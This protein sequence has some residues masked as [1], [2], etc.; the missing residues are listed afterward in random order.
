MSR[1]PIRAH[2]EREIAA[3]LRDALEVPVT[4]IVPTARLI[5]DLG[6]ESIDLL[7]IRFRIE[8]AL[9]L[10]ITNDELLQAFGEGATAQEFRELFTV[11]AMV[12]YLTARL[13]AAGA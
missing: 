5:D 3:I 4:A 2:V 9:G 11:E 13:E 8:K 7:D 1:E 10:R 12:R 6:A